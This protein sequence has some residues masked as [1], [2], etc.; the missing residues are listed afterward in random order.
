MTHASGWAAEPYAAPVTVPEINYLAVALAVVASM[1]VG[2][3]YY[4]PK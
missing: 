1:V 4:H 3:V 2:F